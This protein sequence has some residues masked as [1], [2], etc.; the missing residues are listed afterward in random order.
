V[1][2]AE[3]GGVDAGRERPRAVALDQCAQLG[4]VDVPGLDA[5]DDARA[6]LDHHLVAAAWR[7][8]SARSRALDAVA[9]VAS[10]P[11]RPLRDAATAA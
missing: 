7:A 10:S 8:I 4:A 2:A 1:G 5:V 6:A 9:G 11:M 3:Q